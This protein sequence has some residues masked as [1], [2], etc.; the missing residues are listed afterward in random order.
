MR[1]AIDSKTERWARHLVTNTR[2]VEVETFE[3]VEGVKRPYNG[4]VTIKSGKSFGLTFWSAVDCMK[5]L[6]YVVTR[7]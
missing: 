4:R 3:E 5:H 6:G 2:G 1:K 7:G